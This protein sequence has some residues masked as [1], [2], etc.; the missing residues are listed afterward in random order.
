[1]DP[2]V[3]PFRSSVMSTT[4]VTGGRVDSRRVYYVDYC[5]DFWSLVEG[6]QG[7]DPDQSVPN[8]EGNEVF[9]GP[10]R[11]SGAR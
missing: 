10:K 5:N 8:G 7:S 9:R 4:E 11:G 1:M 3:P 2:D 6:Q